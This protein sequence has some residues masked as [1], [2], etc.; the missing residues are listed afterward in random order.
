MA[1]AAWRA[2]VEGGWTGDLRDVVTRAWA[3]DIEVAALYAVQN[4]EAYVWINLRH[5]DTPA[6][7]WQAWLWC[8]YG[9]AY[10]PPFGI[11]S[12]GALAAFRALDS[13]QE[14]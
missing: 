8:R 10:C 14:A 4:G 6:L 2:Q 1:I 5:A 9:A 13:V 11:L 12:A 3:E 7:S